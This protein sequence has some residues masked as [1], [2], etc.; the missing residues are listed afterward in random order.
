MPTSSRSCFGRTIVRFDQPGAPGR[1][2]CALELGK[3]NVT[4]VIVIS[5]GAVNRRLDLL[6]ETERFRRKP[7]VFHEI[8]GETNELRRKLIDGADHFGRVLHVAF[9]ME[10]SE[11][12]EAAIPRASAQIEFRDAQRCRFDEPCIGPERRWQRQRGQAEKFSP[13]DLAHSNGLR[14]AYSILDLRPPYAIWRLFL[15]IWINQKPHE[16]LSFVGEMG[17][18]SVTRDLVSR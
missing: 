7:R 18:L 9:V 10:V 5:W 12:D 16:P 6:N 17:A 15:L 3:R 2:E 1:R 13:C 4:P 8:A 11:M 14:E